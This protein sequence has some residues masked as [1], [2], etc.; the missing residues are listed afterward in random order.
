MNSSPHAGQAPR[1]GRVAL[2]AAFLAVVSLTAAPRPAQATPIDDAAEAYKVTAQGD[3]DGIVAGAEGG[4][5]RRAPA[6]ASDL[7]L[8]F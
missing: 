3:I 8:H 1:A 5:H 4:I 2:F 7:Q 6:I